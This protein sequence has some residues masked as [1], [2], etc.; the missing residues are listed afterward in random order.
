M[1]NICATYEHRG[2]GPVVATWSNHAHLWWARSSNFQHMVIK[3]IILTS[4]CAKYP[5]KGVHGDVGVAGQ[6][7]AGLAVGAGSK[8]QQTHEPCALRTGL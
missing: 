1:C 4:P 3:H 2:L 8:I 6:V 5:K 7:A